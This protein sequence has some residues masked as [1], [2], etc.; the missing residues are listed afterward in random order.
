MHS[1]PQKSKLQRKRG[2]TMIELIV[3][4]SIFT[5]VTSVVLANY[6]KFSSRIVLEN[7]AHQI[8]LTVREA[9]TYGL[10]VRGFDNSGTTVF[11]GYGVYFPAPGV[12]S[13][14]FTLFADPNDDQRY[15]LSVCRSTGSECLQ[16]S[17]IRSAEHIYLLCGNLKTTGGTIENPGAA[18]CSL[19]SLHVGFRRP[20]PDANIVGYSETDG[21]YRAFS[22]AE[23]VV[24]S[25]RGDMKTIVIWTTGQISVE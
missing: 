15:D 9:Q 1:A 22:D 8:A 12:G 25:P 4:I 10:S 2:F 16:E 17:T 23:V 20:D 6:P 19:S 14:T 21:D 13:K 24:I 18:D 5:M 11:P 7:V 3:T